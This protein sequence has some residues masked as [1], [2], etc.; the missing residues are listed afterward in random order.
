MQTV[1]DLIEYICRET[2]DYLHKYDKL[3]QQDAFL[4]TRLTNKFMNDRKVV[5][6]KNKS[7]VINIQRKRPR[8]IVLPNLTQLELKLTLLICEIHNVTYDQLFSANRTGEVVDARRQLTSFFYT[9][10]AYTYTHVATIFGKD[11]STIIHNVRTHQDLLETDPAYVLKF[12]KFMDSIKK[13]FPEI[14]VKIEEKSELLKEFQKVH[15]QRMLKN[16]KTITENQVN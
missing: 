1:R 3:K 7:I 4:A 9:Y 12:G 10:L 14:L 2:T 8:T 5:K 11:H 13:D 16:G 6:H 15:A